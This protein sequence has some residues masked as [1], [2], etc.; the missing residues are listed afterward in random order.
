LVFLSYCL[1]DN[2]FFIWCRSTARGLDGCM[3]IKTTVS[4]WLFQLHMNILV[5]SLFFFAQQLLT[6]ATPANYGY[7]TYAYFGENG[8]T[9][10]PHSSYGTIDTFKSSHL[11]LPKVYPRVPRLEFSAPSAVMLTLTKPEIISYSTRAITSSTQF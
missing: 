7:F 5:F 10:M 9:C 2:Y 6:N 8:T 1:L 4:D 3:C 11:N